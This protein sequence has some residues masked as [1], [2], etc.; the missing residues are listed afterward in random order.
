LIT[1]YDICLVST[2]PKLTKLSITE[3]EELGYYDFMGYLNVPFFNIGGTPSIDRLAELT[4]LNER[5]RVLEV[6]CGTGGNTCYL[7]NKYRC[8]IVGVDISEQMVAQAQERADEQHLTDKIRFTVGNA[9]ALDFP[10]ASFDFVYTIFTSQFLDTSKA[11][12]EFNRVLKIGGRLG[13]NEMYME[14]ELPTQ[15]KR[16]VDEGER[17]FSDITEL[18]FKVRTG[19]EWRKQFQNTGFID[20]TAEKYTNVAR[21]LDAFKMVK[22]FGGL[23]NITK[24]VWEMLVLAAKSKKIRRRIALINK[25][26]NILVN[27]QEVSNYIGYIL[28]VGA[29]STRFGPLSI[30]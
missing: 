16:K 20:V 14:D 18:P 15:V 11:F 19:S 29:K 8:N 24:T 28:C 13:I 9:Y 21:R 23:W 2:M 1:K 10:D 27:D 25:G 22:E 17:V 6:G 5:T 12:K 3:I 4:G 7:A 26:K 30:I